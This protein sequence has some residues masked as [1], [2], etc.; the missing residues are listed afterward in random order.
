MHSSTTFSLKKCKRGLLS[1]RLRTTLYN[2]VNYYS[3]KIA[4]VVIVNA[5]DPEDPAVKG[6]ATTV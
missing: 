4:P 2:Y 6:P 3:V 5:C 1:P